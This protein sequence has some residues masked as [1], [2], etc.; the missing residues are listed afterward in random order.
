MHLARGVPVRV[1]VPR[2]MREAPRRRDGRARVRVRGRCAV[3][4]PTLGLKHAASD[5]DRSGRRCCR[6]STLDRHSA[7]R[8]HRAGA[9]ASLA[10][11]WQD[12][13]KSEHPRPRRAHRP[14]RPHALAARWERNGARTPAQPGLIGSE[15]RP[16]DDRG[17]LD[18]GEPSTLREVGERALAHAGHLLPVQASIRV[19]IHHNTLHAFQ[20]LPF[21]P[22]CGKAARCSGRSRTPRKSASGRSSL[23]VASRTSTSIACRSRSEALHGGD[24]RCHRRTSR[25]GPSCAA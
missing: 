11:E 1:S 6:H 5:S 13:S 17:L 14:R 20:H 2:P 7:G 12:W 8:S 19:F 25:R 3:H 22:R 21:E 23:A 10:D 15:Q 16:L 18:H 9:S 24:R 4:Q